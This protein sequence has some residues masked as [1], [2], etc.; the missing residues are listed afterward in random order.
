MFYGKGAGKLPT[1]SA[2]VADIM[3]C[4]KHLKK[5]KYLD[6]TDGDGSIVKPYAETVYPVYI[7]AAGSDKKALLEKARELFADVNEIVRSGSA[8]N[9]LAFTTGDMKAAE[10]DKAAA[11]FEECGAKVLSRIRIA[12]L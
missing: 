2:V 8:E 10:I 6:W 3:D 9:E 4:V 7:R 12:D 11:A 5:R 1:A